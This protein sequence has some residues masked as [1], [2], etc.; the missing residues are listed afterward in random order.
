MLNL[1]VRAPSDLLDSRR[2][3]FIGHKRYLEFTLDSAGFD[4]KARVASMIPLRLGYG[5]LYELVC[6][7]H[8]LRLALND[9]KWLVVKAWSI[10]L[11]E[12]GTRIRRLGARALSKREVL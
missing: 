8:C 1:M 11:T 4:S 5:V 7:V 9:H 2:K 3:G 10:L 6:L 12:Q